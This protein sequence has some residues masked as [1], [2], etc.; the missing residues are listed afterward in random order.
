MPD[1]A[2]EVEEESKMANFEFHDGDGDGGL[3]WCKT[4]QPWGTGTYIGFLILF[5]FVIAG[6]ILMWTS[7]VLAW[8]SIFMGIF[9]FIALMIAKICSAPVEPAKNYNNN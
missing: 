9:G 7:I 3:E 2:D 8:L 5:V 1:E 6:V 4:A